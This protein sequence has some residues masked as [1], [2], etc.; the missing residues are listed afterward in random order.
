[1][2][3]KMPLLFDPKVALN[4]GLLTFPHDPAREVAPNMLHTE[5]NVRAFPARVIEEP[6]F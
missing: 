3:L 6:R 2:T 5:V 1:M 4:S